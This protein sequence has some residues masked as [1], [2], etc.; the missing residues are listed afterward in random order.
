MRPGELKTYRSA[1]GRSLGLASRMCW[2]LT[3][4]PLAAAHSQ[5][6]VVYSL[7]AAG[8]AL[9]VLG[10]VLGFTEPL[11]RRVERMARLQTQI[12]DRIYVG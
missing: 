6:R 7:L 9:G 2:T 3:V 10:N 1:V 11:S 8:Q 5:Q 12:K 4:T